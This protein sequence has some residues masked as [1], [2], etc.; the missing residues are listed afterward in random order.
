MAAKPQL[1]GL[2]ALAAIIAHAVPARAGRVETQERAAKK[3]CL[4]GDPSRGVGI[5]ADLFIDTDDPVYIYNQGRC[6]E[7]NNRYEEAIPKFREYLR[8]ATKATEA[9]KV[10]AE[11]HIADCERLLGKKV[12]AAT[13]APASEPTKPPVAVAAAVPVPPFP[14]PQPAP[15]PATVTPEPTPA[16]VVASQ[17]ST[18][19]TREGR[20]LRIAGIATASVGAALLVGALVANLK[21]NGMIDDL[22]GAYEPGKHDSSKTYHTLA[23]AGYGV[24]AACLA[25]GA[26]LYYLGWRAGNVGVAPVVTS[27]GVAAVVT[28]AF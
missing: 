17:T 11:K 8:K 28:G 20:G 19:P 18:E 1:L 16:V 26:V 4:T 6:Y 10:D 27:G 21:Y 13:I 7:Q 12:E 24:G 15:A 22:Q 3:A 9:E 14:A 5:L 2:F 23:I 25:G